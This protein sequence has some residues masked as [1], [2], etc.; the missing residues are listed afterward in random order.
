MFI[1][2][3]KNENTHSVHVITKWRWKGVGVGQEELTKNYVVLAPQMGQAIM[4]NTVRKTQEISFLKLNG[5]PAIVVNSFLY[6]G[7]LEMTL[8][9][10]QCATACHDGHYTTTWVLHL[11]CSEVKSSQPTLYLCVMLIVIAGH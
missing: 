11:Y 3:G 1:F 5:N 10:G 4:P 7:H 2:V 6:S 8:H 9:V